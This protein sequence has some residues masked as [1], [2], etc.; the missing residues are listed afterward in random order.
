MCVCVRVCVCEYMRA[1][2]NVCAC[3]LVCVHGCACVHACAWC[4]H[5][6]CV[7]ACMRVYVHIKRPS[8][9]ADVRAVS[10]PSHISTLL[11]NSQLL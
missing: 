8:K 3:V 4:V 10:F 7:R 11:G 5:V 2:V 9:R 6:V 1:C